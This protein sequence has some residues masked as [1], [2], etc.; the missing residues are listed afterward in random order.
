MIR[1][2]YSTEM[3]DLFESIMSS[4]STAWN[5]SF[6]PSENNSFVLGSW[7]PQGRLTVAP[8]SHQVSKNCPVY[9]QPDP[10]NADSDGW[11]PYV[12]PNLRRFDDDVDFNNDSEDWDDEPNDGIKVDVEV[13]NWDGSIDDDSNSPSTSPEQ[14]S[15]ETTENL[16]QIPNI[17]PPPPPPTRPIN[18]GSSASHSTDT[19]R[20]SRST[21]RRTQGGRARGTARGA[22]LNRFVQ[23][24]LDIHTDQ[25]D[26][27]MI[28]LSDSEINPAVENVSN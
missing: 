6:N 25:N 27:D 13:L 2:I 23:K 11:V 1:N 26:E 14:S 18:S 22:R 3:G 20:T 8:P 19:S 24:L 10:G 9:P 16:N 5:W 21:N 4:G 15:E 7:L 12:P 28:I 17:P